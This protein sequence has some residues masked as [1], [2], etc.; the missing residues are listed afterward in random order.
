IWGDYKIKGD[1]SH[2]S[3]KGRA[4][5]YIYQDDTW[6]VSKILTAKDGEENDQFGYS[7]AIHNDLAVVC[8]R[9]EDNN[10]SGC[11]Y[12]GAA[13]IFQ[14][15]GNTWTEIQK[16]VANDRES[17]DFFGE[18]VSIYKDYIIVGAYGEDNSNSA[19]NYFGAAY[20]FTQDDNTW[21]QVQKLKAT[22]RNQSD[23]Y[24]Y[25]V[26]INETHAVVGAYGDDEAG[27]NL[28]AVYIYLK[29]NDEWNKS[30]KINGS[31]TYFGYYVTIIDNTIIVKNNSDIEYYYPL[32]STIS[33]YIKTPQGSPQIGSNIIFTN[34][35][36]STSTDR[37][38]YFTHEVPIGWSGIV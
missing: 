28:G 33:G 4:V 34:D 25:A 24:G 16:I 15:N 27:N 29:Q 2:S 7:V 37:Y 38:G 13:Y 26:A 31:V 22:Q 17:R 20:I 9:G 32:F 35:G 30:I 23:Y 5:I 11:D 36:G 1:S 10:E 14:R 18:D 3:S 19:N 6:R 8:A 12:I 21:K